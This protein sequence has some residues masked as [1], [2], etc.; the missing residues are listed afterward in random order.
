[1]QNDLFDKIIL[2]AKDL[3]KIYDGG[4]LANYN[5][6]FSVKQGEIHALVGENGAGKS[7]LMKMLFGIEKITSGDVFY[8]GKKVSF[9]SSKDAIDTGLG[10]VHQHFM[11]I[12]SFTI[13]E[14]LMLGVE[15]K[16]NLFFTDVKKC[17]N[18]AEDIAKKF[19]FQI[20]AKKKVRD[21]SV[22]MKQKIEILKAL[23]RGA[24][25]L[26]LD[27]PT[28]VLTPQETDQLFEQ[29]I[30]LK[31]KGFTVIFISHKLNEVKRLCD[32]LTILKNGRSLGTY[33]VNQLS[34]V[35]ISNL[36]VGHNVIL[37]YEKSDVEIGKEMLKVDKV[38]FKD[39][40]GVVKLDN[41]SLSVHEGEIL[42]IAGIEGNGQ[43]EFSKIVSGLI[44]ADSGAILLDSKDISNLEPGK[45]RNM[46][47]SHVPEDRM[48]NGCVLE[49]P[50]DDNIISNVY[51]SFAKQGMMDFKKVKS[52]TETLIKKYV[53]KTQSTKSKLKGL[54]GG[55]IQKV[56]IAR[57]FSADANVMLIN[58]PTRGI[59]VG[60]EELIHKKILGMR[61]KRKAIILISADLT[62]LL[63]LSDRIVIFSK[64]KV[65]GNIM[66][67][68]NATE[69]DLG[70]Y[71][72][73]L[74][75]DKE[76]A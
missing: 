61:E 1:M 74:K 13:A 63:S 55:N 69:K 58:H 31:N 71:M 33:D 73:G 29:L 60:A 44:R 17:I 34:E 25:V 11:L 57:E 62:E 56:I 40:F 76:G 75:V 21:I 16:K 46:G 66:D 24:K 65:V 15:K 6:N 39:K 49:L 43:S 35:E 22:G 42:G 9:S 32:R 64:G 51:S 28:A 50:L 10:M 70:L 4:I 20:D 26:I 41:C 72:L 8:D 5:I 52:H 18:E 12:P 59:D 7:T 48:E 68:K 2:E 23:Y 54:S 27:E 36:M 47:F 45:I 37:E 38:C 19:N 30:N 14:N 67:V 53:I 3:T